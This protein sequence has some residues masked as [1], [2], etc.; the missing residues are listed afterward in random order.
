MNNI[1]K[2]IFSIDN[3]KELLN[4]SIRQRQKL[5]KAYAILPATRCQRKTHCCSMLPEVTLLEALFAIQQL[6]DMTPVRRRHLIR[7]IIGYFF[8]N[9]VEVLSC[10]F[11]D[12]Q[13]CLIYQNRFFGCRAYGLWSKDY[14]EKLVSHSREAKVH[15]QRQWKYLGVPL[16]QSVIDFQVPY[17]QYVELDGDDVID[18]RKL[19]QAADAIDALSRQFSQWHQ[20]FSERYFFDLSFLLASLAFGFIEAVKMKF[21]IVREIVI[22]RDRTGLDKIFEDLPDIFAGFA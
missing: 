7:T 14:Y 9:P 18:D 11:L 8:L 2:L 1:D 21:V 10:P 16:P 22:N 3:I 13:D 4:T 20:L 19:L 6:L 5:G 12:F 15:L 17:C